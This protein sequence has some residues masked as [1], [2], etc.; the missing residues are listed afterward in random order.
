A[1]VASRASRPLLQR[2][3]DRLATT[4][5]ATRDRVGFN[6]AALTHLRREWDAIHA[7]GMPDPLAPPQKDAA[8]GP[9][10]SK[11]KAANTKNKRKR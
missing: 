11:G 3:R 4:L 1:L 2:T 9:P 10:G 6:F 8:G 7:A 5:R